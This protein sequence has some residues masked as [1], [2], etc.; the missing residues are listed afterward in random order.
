MRLYSVSGRFAVESCVAAIT[1]LIF[2][3]VLLLVGLAVFFESGLP[4]L[5]LQTR[6]GRNGRLFRLVKIRTM[7]SRASGS[8]ITVSGDPRVTRVGRVLRKFKLD[9]L[10]QLWNV[11][12]GQ[13]SLVGPRPEV[14]EFVDLSQP[15]WRSVLRVRPGITDPVSIAYRDE[16]NLLATAN[17]AVRFYRESVLPD[18]LARTLCYLEN[19]SAWRDLLVIVQTIRCAA[20]PRQFKSKRAEVVRLGD[21]R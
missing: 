9:E 5:F 12:R 11:V 18:K 14:P 1:L 21:P 8:G 10:P 4:I 7:R 19:R 17:D 3:P 13:M 2:S 20:F 6:V 15:V 16:E